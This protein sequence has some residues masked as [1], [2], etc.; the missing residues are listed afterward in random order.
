MVYCGLDLYLKIAS[1]GNFCYHSAP[2]AC[3]RVH[4]N[5]LTVLGSRNVEDFRMQHAVT[6][7]RHIN[8][9]IPASRMATLRLF[10]ASIEVNVALAAA[11]AGK[12]GTIGK[13]IRSVLFLGPAG[14]AR[15]LFYSR[16]VDR[17]LPRLRAAVAGRF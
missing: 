4:K 5:S 7:D 3:F 17:A 12:F 6:V 1:I 15:Y 14:M 2:L 10:E 11:V 8:K 16:I 13:A 9:V